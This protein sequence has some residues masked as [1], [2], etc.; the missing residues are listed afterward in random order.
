MPG[1]RPLTKILVDGGDPD[2]TLRVR[3][4]LG[5][6]DGQT[7]NPTFVDQESGRTASDRVR[8]K[9]H[10]GRTEGGVEEDCS[11]DLAPCRQCGSLHRGLR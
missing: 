1:V 4:L 11:E 2:E 5:F 10:L 8:P 7:T 9:T 6:V 3:N